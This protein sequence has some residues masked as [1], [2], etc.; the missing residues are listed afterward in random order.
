MEKHWKLF[1]RNQIFFLKR[2]WGVAGFLGMA[3]LKNLK[4]QIS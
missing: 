1:S 3:F 4:E 2:K